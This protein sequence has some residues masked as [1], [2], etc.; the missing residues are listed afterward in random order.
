MISD[1][2]SFLLMHV[3]SSWV[4]TTC[5]N[6]GMFFAYRVGWTVKMPKKTD[7]IRARR[8]SCSRKK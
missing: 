6:S 7:N 3:G 5:K 4:G 2:G 1:D 8:P